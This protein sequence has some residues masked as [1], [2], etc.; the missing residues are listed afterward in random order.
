[1]RRSIRNCSKSS[2]ERGSGER[3]FALLIVLWTLVLLAFMVAHLSAAG[4]VEARIAGNLRANAAAEADADGAVF[5]AAFHLIDGSSRH[6]NPDGRPHRVAVADGEADLTMTSLAGRINP[7]LASPDLLAALLRVQGISAGN[8]ATVAEAIVD[9]RSP[10]TDKNPL[11][12]KLAVYRAARMDHGPPG[13]AFQS[14]DEVG[15]VL[16]VTPDILA[17][18]RP[19]MSLF[20]DSDPDPAYADPIVLAALQEL[21]AINPAA[22]PAARTARN[23][24]PVAIDVRVAT[25]LGA[26]FTR[27]AVVRVGP[28]LA[29][30]YAVLDWREDLAD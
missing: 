17:L 16:G 20:Q 15:R 2:P 23:T 10:P 12:A 29:H 24:G 6:W 25:A 14:L 22:P 28:G 26:R 21:A 8:A 18:L 9:W 7:N 27:H 13:D 4:R 30:G 5:E 11:T 19:H 3:G 1:M